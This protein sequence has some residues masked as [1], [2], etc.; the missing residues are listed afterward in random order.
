MKKGLIVVLSIIEVFSI[1]LAVKSFNNKE[2]ILDDVKLKTIVKEKETFA[3]M[4]QKS[5]KSGYEEYK[6]NNAV[7]DTF[8][9]T[10]YIFNNDKS[11][12]IDE[13][14]SLIENSIRYKNNT[15]EIIAGKTLSCFVYFD[16]ENWVYYGWDGVVSDDMSTAMGDHKM[17]LKTNTGVEIYSGLSKIAPYND[18]IIVQVCTIIN[19]EEICVDYLDPSRGDLLPENSPLTDG[20]NLNCSIN[21][22]NAVCQYTTDEMQEYCEMSNNRADCYRYN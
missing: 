6:V 5:D 11:G 7:S 10:G 21:E 14:G 2:I 18:K 9:T 1:F 20:N 3:I 13:D 12:C 8:P 22:Y 19:N 17:V 4:V 15:V 16:I